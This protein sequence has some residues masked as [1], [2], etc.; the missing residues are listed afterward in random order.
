[1]SFLPRREADYLL[2]LTT[3][4]APRGHVRAQRPMQ[5]DG[6]ECSEILQLSQVCAVDDDTPKGNGQLSPSGTR[7]IREG[8][9]I[10]ITPVPQK[11]TH[12]WG[13]GDR[14]FLENLPWSCAY[15]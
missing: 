11:N 7:E 13:R 6:S 8:L 10:F 3:E 2:W 12:L 1:M 5:D 9:P 4:M 14:V 15:S